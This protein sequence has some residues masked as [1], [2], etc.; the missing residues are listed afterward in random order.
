MIKYKFTLLTLLFFATLTPLKAMCEKDLKEDTRQMHPH[1]F[2]IKESGLFAGFGLTEDESFVWIDDMENSSPSRKKVSLRG[3]HI[4][5]EGTPKKH[6]IGSYDLESMKGIP[7][8][9]K[10]YA[11]KRMQNCWECFER[12]GFN[13]AFYHVSRDQLSLQQQAYNL[14]P[15]CVYLASFQEEGALKV[16]LAY[17]PRLLGR[18]LEQGALAATVIQ[19]FPDAYQARELEKRISETYHIPEGF[20]CEK[21][22]LWLRSPFSLE[23]ILTNLK[24]QKEKI[25]SELQLLD[26]QTPICDLWSLYKIEVVDFETVEDR[27][28]LQQKVQGRYLG[29]V[30]DALIYEHNSQKYMCGLKKHV[31][32]SVIRILRTLK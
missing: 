20:S 21:K 16:G 24:N 18:W 14:R 17:T 22:R 12:T 30:G 1:H 6:C 15:H 11:L 28:F 29:L 31:G 13:P 23:K 25:I 32:S 9:A 7:C 10:A 3:Q 2:T 5:I 27:T 19:S 8:M 4:E 26:P